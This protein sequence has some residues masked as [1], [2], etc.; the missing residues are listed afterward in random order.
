MH[1]PEIL[2]LERLTQDDN[3]SK[4]SLRYI[5]QGLG[6]AQRYS[7]CLMCAKSLHYMLGR[8]KAT[9]VQFTDKHCALS[10][11][12][13]SNLI[14]FFRS[15]FL[16]GAGGDVFT[17]YLSKFFYFYFLLFFRAEFLCVVLAILKLAL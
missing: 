17:S 16:R 3:W 13:Y 12:Q 1:M 2:A 9:D 6:R 5:A 8:E 14:S 7:A 15:F 4:A 10:W 11:T